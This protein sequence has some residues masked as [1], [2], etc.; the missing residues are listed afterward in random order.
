MD[1]SLIE[2]LIVDDVPQNL[3]YLSSL[4]EGKGFCV[5]P[6]TNGKNALRAA[7]AKAPHIILL[8]ICMPQMDGYAVCQ[9][10]KKDADLCNIPIIF[11]SALNETFDKTKAFSIGGVDY[12]TKPFDAEEVLAR[13][14]THLKIH[15]LTIQLQEK[16]DQL[17]QTIHDLKKTIEEREQ[18]REQLRKVDSKLSLLSEEEAK[19]WGIS[20]FV[21]KSKTMER[22]LSDIRKVQNVKSTNVLVLGESGT[23]KELI[24]RAIHFGGRRKG[25]FMALN[26][27]AIPSDLFESVCFGHIAG[28]F[29]GATSNKKGVFECADKGTLFLDEIGDM[30]LNL[31]TKLLRAIENGE[32]T[33]VGS[34]RSIKVDVRIIAATNSSITQQVKE[35][36]FRQDLYFRI[37]RFIVKLPPL[38]ERRDDIHLLTSHFIEILA[39]EMGRKPPQLSSEVVAI[40][41]QYYFPGNI[42]ELKNII[43]NALIRCGATIHPEHLQLFESDEDT[44]EKLEA[45]SLLSVQSKEQVI[46]QYVEKRG[47]INNRQCRDLLEI[48]INNASYLLKKL[49]KTGNLVREGQRR[50]SYYRL[51]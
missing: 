33:P 50:W 28:A 8:D 14:H 27:C 4:L 6:A 45:P 3:Q 18:A 20:G 13:I 21:S 46:L 31:Q 9:K 1:N 22:I 2:V 38:R 17:Q 11:I 49:H 41:E 44:E 12:I 15:N 7:K 32:V 10:F 36:S 35:G 24:A 40:L 47:T 29:T 37:A 23:G 42:R 39:K 5:R 51:P 16:N 34:N 48:D 26:C 25:A 43:E 30:P 19:R